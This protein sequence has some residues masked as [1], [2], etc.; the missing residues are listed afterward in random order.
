MKK[1]FVIVLSL[2]L[3]GCFALA[4]SIDWANMTDEEVNTVID[5]GKAEIERRGLIGNTENITVF[6]ENG[7]S[8][9]ITSFAIDTESWIYQPCLTVDFIITN[10]SNDDYK[11]YI[12][13]VAINGWEV[14]YT[15]YAEVAAGHKAKDKFLFKLADSDV[16]T[17]EQLETFEISF[18]Y[19]KPGTTFDYIYTNPITINIK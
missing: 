16:E 2:L 14:E 4:E 10:T 13:N 12:D 7:V 11:I 17:E 3:V 6:D 9:I 19:P 15:G 8:I 18:F 5:N 1:L